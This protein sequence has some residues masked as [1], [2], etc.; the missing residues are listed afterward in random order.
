M[1]HYMGT[2]ARAQQT[3]QLKLRTSFFRFCAPANSHFVWRGRGWVGRHEP[4]WASVSSLWRQPTTPLGPIWPY[5][6]WRRVGV[7][8]RIG[9]RNS[10]FGQQVLCPRIFILWRG[11]GPGWGVTNAGHRCSHSRGPQPPPPYALFQIGYILAAGGCGP[12]C[13]AHK[14]GHNTRSSRGT[15]GSMFC[16]F[17][18]C[19]PAQHELIQVVPVVHVTCCCHC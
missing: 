12:P 2:P 8:R 7:G 9:W 11:W 18:F 13:G 16:M 6:M 4:G 14:L 17:L 15:V 1:W 19:A 5:H 3:F 10:V